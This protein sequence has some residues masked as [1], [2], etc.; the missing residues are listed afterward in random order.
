MT[1]KYILRD[2]EIR[3]NCRVLMNNGD[4][5][6]SGVGAAEDRRLNAIP[7]NPPAVRL[8]DS[9]KNFNQGALPCPVFTG[10]RKDTPGMKPQIDTAQDLNGP[11]T[12]GDTAKFDDRRH[13][14]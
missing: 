14:T 11:K 10:Q 4:A 2:R 9:P 5:L 12:F 3:K 1:D 13:R 6:A 8:M 7:K